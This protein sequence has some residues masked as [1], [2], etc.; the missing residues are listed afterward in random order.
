MMGRGAHPGARASRPHA[1]P[2]RSAQFP[3]NGAPGHPAG[4]NAMG[5]AGAASWRPPGARASRP[6]AVPSRSA[7]FP[8]NGAPGH[9]AG[10]NG[11]GSAGAE[12]WRPPGSAGVSPACCSVA[13]RSVSLRWRSRVGCPSP[14]A[15]LPP[16]GSG[17]AL[18]FSMPIDTY[19]RRWSLKQVRR[20]SCLWEFILGSSSFQY[21]DHQLLLLSK[22]PPGRGL[23][24]W[25]HLQFPRQQSK[26]P[27][28]MGAGC[29]Q[30][31]AR[32]SLQQ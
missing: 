28:R 25:S 22:G 17:R 9:P 19:G 32:P 29:A 26:V 27:F 5:P 24:G 8:R 3:R 1:V 7:Q 6:H 11:M 30:A 18:P 4:R 13:F 10:G 12:S 20:S 21:D 31:T 16:R 23:R 2:S 14:V 15:P